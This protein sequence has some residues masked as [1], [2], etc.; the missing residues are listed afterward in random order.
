MQNDYTHDYHS[1]R[2][3]GDRKDGVCIR[4]N[5][6]KSS[7]RRSAMFAMLDLE[8][9]ELVVIQVLYIQYTFNENTFHHRP[10]SAI[11]MTLVCTYYTRRALLE[12]QKKII[13]ST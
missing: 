8:G 6:Q 11:F 13:F 12:I 9:R 3:I 7:S 1:F 10:G 2:A 5:G 4:S